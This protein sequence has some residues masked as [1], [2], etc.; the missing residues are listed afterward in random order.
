MRA[1]TI[2]AAAIGLLLVGVAVTRTPGQET[3]VAG[4]GACCYPSGG[5]LEFGASS[6]ISTGGTWQG[7]GTTCAETDCTP[8]PTVVGI[9]AVLT[10]GGSTV[11]VFRGWSDGQIDFFNSN[12]CN[13]AFP[14]VIVPGSC[15]TDVNRDG[16]TGINDFLALLG[17]WGACR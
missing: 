16:D 8:Q 15:P 5:C 9:S 3:T 2:L 10:T 11:A 17:G 7:S 14:C 1:T 6:C 12:Q 13:P 4:Q